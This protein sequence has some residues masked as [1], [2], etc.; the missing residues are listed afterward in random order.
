[1]NCKKIID[2][3]VKKR[4]IEDDL[5]GPHLQP[6][7]QINS[8]QPSENHDFTAFVVCANCSHR[9]VFNVL[10]NQLATCTSC[11]TTSSGKFK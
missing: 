5:P 7:L 1:M 4:R 3:P 8:P 2:L 6:Q 9:F 10:S 11:R